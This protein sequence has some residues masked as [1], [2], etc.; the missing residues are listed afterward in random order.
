MYNIMNVFNAIELY[1]CEQFKKDKYY[2]MY[3]L[4]HTHTKKPTEKA[5]RA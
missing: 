3:I 2:A 4:P 5:D 1:T